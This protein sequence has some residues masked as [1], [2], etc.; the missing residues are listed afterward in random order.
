MK[1]S[2]KGIKRILNAFKF[3]YDGFIATFK[4]EEAFNRTKE[5]N[6]ELRYFLRS[7]L[8][9]LGYIL[10]DSNDKRIPNELLSR[11]KKSFKTCSSS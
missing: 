1:R 11:I 2:K 6:F 5:S 10:L 8:P 7:N 3:S 4:S 9:S